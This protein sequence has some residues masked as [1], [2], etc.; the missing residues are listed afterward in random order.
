MSVVDDA[1]WQT[2]IGLTS[3]SV[4]LAT[5]ATV[6]APIAT[7]HVWAL[8]IAVVAAAV[9][10]AASAG[11]VRSI[12]CLAAA[13]VIAQPFMHV[14]GGLMHPDLHLADHST[15][16]GLVLLAYHVA[17]FVVLTTSAAAIDLAGGVLLARFRRLVR[18]ALRTGPRLQCDAV[19]PR[20][21]FPNQRHK[22]R[23]RARLPDRRGPPTSAT[24]LVH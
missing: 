9:V 3:G 23:L 13:M 12:L 22:Q 18:I 20:V 5:I 7:D 4:A 6:M 11:G 2:V 10:R 14:V 24:A 1:R 17:L 15:V 16:A 21:E 8:G 19:R